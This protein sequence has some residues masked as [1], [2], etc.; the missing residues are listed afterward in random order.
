ML[1]ALPVL[2]RVIFAGDRRD[3]ITPLLRDKL[4]WLRARVRIT[5]KLSLLVYK[6]INGL[7]HLIF[8]VCSCPL[9][10]FP[11]VPPSALQLVETLSFLVPGDV[12]ATGHFASLVQ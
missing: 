11:A 4:H 2:I 6:A 8:K 7:A 12:S 9:Q 10:L 3:H 1:L 5:F